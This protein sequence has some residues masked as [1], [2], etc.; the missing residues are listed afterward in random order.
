MYKSVLTFSHSS[1]ALNQPIANDDTT[2]MD[3]IVGLEE[4]K[5][6]YKAVSNEQALRRACASAVTKKE[7]A[8]IQYL[9][10][11]AKV[12][13]YTAASDGKTPLELAFDYNLKK[14]ESFEKD[15][16]N[17]QV[18]DKLKLRLQ[19]FS[20]LLTKEY[21]LA[22]L[23]KL[24]R[25]LS[26]YV[27][28]KLN[29][30]P[31][32]IAMH[33]NIYWLCL[34]RMLEEAILNASLK[35]EFIKIDKHKI[36]Q[37][38]PIFIFE[39]HSDPATGTFLSLML[40]ELKQMG[41]KLFLTEQPLGFDANKSLTLFENR[42]K[43]FSLICPSDYVDRL[44]Y[45]IDSI[46]KIKSENFAL[47]GMDNLTLDPIFT[48]AFL[49]LCE[50]QYQLISDLLLPLRDKSMFYHMALYGEKLDGA[51]I[52]LVGA[53][54]GP[55][56]MAHFEAWSGGLDQW[57]PCATNELFD[58]ADPTMHP[59]INQLISSGAV[60]LCMRPDTQAAA[61]EAFLAALKMP[62]HTNDTATANK[63]KAFH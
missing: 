23:E 7:L 13:M 36:Y 27:R 48:D 39:N 16:E 17:P 3:M 56:I 11:I 46:N 60:N 15:L 58:P 38:K 26:V 2:D 49:P 18:R 28:E 29:K 1:T 45:A 25:F 12:D 19:I 32:H 50:I 47:L 34:K 37:R 35:S 41:Y 52:T 9:L 43:R 6:K 54:H 42:L 33:Y 44:K 51:L 4:I 5:K 62:A 61:I 24:E 21:D 57:L 22:L 31:V 8:D 30:Y 10:E 53:A 40:P 20:Y 55:G 14:L 63:M 59:A